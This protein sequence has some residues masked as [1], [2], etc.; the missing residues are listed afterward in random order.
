MR[1]A[2]LSDIHANIQALDACLEHAQTQQVDRFAFL[3]DMVGYGADPTAVLDRIMQYTA[4]GAVALKGNHD[5]MAISPPADV[6]TVGESTAHWT[7][8]Q[9]SAAQRDWIEALPLTTQ[10]DTVLLVHASADSPAQWHYVYDSRAAN[11]SLD[12]AAAWPGVRYVFGGHVHKQTLYYRGA[13]DGLMMFV[14]Q[15]GVPIP[16]PKRRQWLA[17]VGSVGQPRDG[18]PA[19]M[20]A[21][22]D[23]TRAQLTFHRIAYDHLAAALAIRRAGLPAFFAS[24]LEEGQ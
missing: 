14:P 11:A 5:E 23:T 2:L 4:K 12:A 19:A 21:L 20:Y 1:L 18:K 17:T 6:K 22:L 15:A 9:L 24:R 10:M 8:Q 16:V 7:H 13:A 3:G